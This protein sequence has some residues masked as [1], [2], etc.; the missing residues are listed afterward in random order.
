MYILKYKGFIQVKYSFLFLN[1]NSTVRCS[2]TGLLG[3]RFVFRG[4]STGIYFFNL[5]RALTFHF[6]GGRDG[7]LPDIQGYTKFG[8]TIIWLAQSR[9]YKYFL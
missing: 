7:F 3:R 6:V 8:V 1:E 4:W 5:Y 2:R 9:N